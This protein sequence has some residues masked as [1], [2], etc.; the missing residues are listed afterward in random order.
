MRLLELVVSGLVGAHLGVWWWLLQSTLDE[1][2]EAK[3]LTPLRA[4]VF[5]L[6]MFAWPLLLFVPKENDDAKR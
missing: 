5:A 6:M 4:C 3:L 1:I 2:P